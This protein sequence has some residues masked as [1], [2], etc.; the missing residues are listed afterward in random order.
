MAALTCPHCQ[1]SKEVPEEK[2]PTGPAKFT[3]PKC[4][5]L[6]SWPAEREEEKPAASLVTI[7]CPHCAFSSKVLRNRLPSDVRQVRCKHCGQ[8][9]YFHPDSLPIE[10]ELPERPVAKRPVVPQP[11]ARRP[12]K[13]ARPVAPEVEAPPTEFIAGMPLPPVI[14][15]FSRSWNYFKQRV[16]LLLG[17]YLVTVV[18]TVI[19][20]LG[21]GLLVGIA[22]GIS[23][24]PGPGTWILML[25]AVLLAMVLMTWGIAAMIYATVDPKLRFSDAFSIAKQRLWAFSWVLGLLGFIIGGGFFLLFVPGLIFMTWFLFSQYIFALED[26]GGMASLCKSREYVRGYFWNVLLRLVV[27]WVIAFLLTL[28]LGW[29]PLVGNIVSLIILPYTLIYQYLLYC[30]LRAVKGGEVSSSCSR[31]EKA[32]WLGIPALGYLV[33]PVAFFAAGGPAMLAGLVLNAQLQQRGG[34]GTMQPQWSPQT[35]IEEKLGEAPPVAV[36]SSR[37]ELLS[38]LKKSRLEAK[39]GEVSLGPAVLALDQF[40]DSSS[41]PHFWIRV[42]TIDFPNASLVSEQALRI[43]IDQV[44][45]DEDRN[46]YDSNNIFEKPYFQRVAL[47]SALPGAPL[48]GLR[49]VYLKSGTDEDEILQVTGSLHLSLPAGIEVVDLTPSM[50]G[51]E[52]TVAGHDIAFKRLEGPAVTLELK[53]VDNLLKVVGY[54]ASGKPLEESGS[55]WNETSGVTSRTITFHGEVFSV[56]LYVA[57]KLV[58][59]DYP[60]VL[61]RSE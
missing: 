4:N 27:L 49:D 31:N 25:I 10:F 2:L 46:R 17:I 59:Q 21:I 42:R 34:E 3:C 45:D 54:N 48:E 26:E 50:M 40:W 37:K 60:F 14:D 19:P 47:Q 57:G 20:S 24:N 8:D 53:D 52:F 28:V 9:F 15:L 23:G 6:F 11:V 36:R 32:L 38:L 12:V 1:F 51:K 5:E 22:A 56:R 55:S 61:N 43:S 16:W 13:K 44:I 7:S 29:I 41:A 18:I 30:D 33:L 58:G 35:V 39:P